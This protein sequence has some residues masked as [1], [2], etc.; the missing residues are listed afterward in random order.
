MPDRTAAARSQILRE[1][2]DIARAQREHLEGDRLDL[3]LELMDERDQLM[4]QLER[5]LA[6]GIDM[7]SNVIAFRSP[8]TSE[9]VEQ[10]ELALDTLIRGILEHD[11]QNEQMLAEKMDV[12]RRDLPRLQRGHRAHAGYRGQV[13]GGHYIDRVS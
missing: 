10:D 7:P 1:I 11:Q 6:E 9:W 8:A 13:D 12:I 3:V 2:F 4:V 5:L